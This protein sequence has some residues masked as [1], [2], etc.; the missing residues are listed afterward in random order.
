MR[1]FGLAP[2]IIA[3][4]LAVGC[5]DGGAEI[6]I[7]DARASRIADG[8]VVVETDVV[9]KERLGGSLGTYCART[10]FVTQALPVTVCYADLEDGDRKTLRF[11][12]DGAL[13]VGV[14]ITVSVWVDGKGEGRTLAAP[15]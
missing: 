8:R 14:P 7:E 6:F 13:P 5:S 4:A 11:T 9:A 2:S 10:T 3:A 15:P 1:A 12:S